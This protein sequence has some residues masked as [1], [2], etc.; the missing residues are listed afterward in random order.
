VSADP[1]WFFQFV[2]E[3]LA[4]GRVPGASAEFLASTLGHGKAA[5]EEEGQGGLHVFATYLFTHN[6]RVAILSFALGFAF[7]VPTM[8]LIF[9]NGLSLGPMMAVFAG[10]G[11]GVDFGGWLAIHGTTELFA[12][13]LSG[14]AGLRIGTAMLLP[15]DLDRMTALS[16]AG[17][18]AGKVMVG[19]VIMMLT[20]GLLEGFGRQ[21]ITDTALRYAVGG[22]MLTFWLAFYYARRS[23]STG[24]RA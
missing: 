12:I 22:V 8:L 6:S 3:Q 23:G 24:F 13:I 17:R 21:L 20:A 16:R 18:T 9:Y 10:K 1:E 15:G 19:V 11:L 2:P 14:A 5:A 4:G 7:G